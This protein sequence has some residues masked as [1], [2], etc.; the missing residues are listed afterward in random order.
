[1]VVELVS[2]VVVG[3]DMVGS[4]VGKSMCLRVGVRACKGRYRVIVGNRGFE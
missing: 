4:V 1:M 2:V 3:M